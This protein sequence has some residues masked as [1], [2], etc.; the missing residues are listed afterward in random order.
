MLTELIAL[1]KMSVYILFTIIG[2]LINIQ[3]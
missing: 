1:P 2:L 3:G